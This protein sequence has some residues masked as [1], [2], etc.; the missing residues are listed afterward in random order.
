MRTGLALAA[1]LTALVP[2]AASPGAPV[3]VEWRSGEILARLARSSHKADFF[4]S[5]RP[6]K[7]SSRF[8]PA[9]G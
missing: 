2:A 3:L 8:I 6:L 1:L 7:A 5:A 9:R 4:L